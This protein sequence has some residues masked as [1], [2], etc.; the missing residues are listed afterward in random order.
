VI[1]DASHDGR[2]GIFFDEFAP[3]LLVRTIFCN[4]QPILHVLTCR[5]GVVAWWHA[6]DIFRMFYAPRA[7]VIGK[8]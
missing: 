2:E 1:T 3:S 7:G 8:A 6:V 5:A 4:I